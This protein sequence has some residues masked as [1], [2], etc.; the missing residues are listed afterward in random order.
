LEI[1]LRTIQRWQRHQNEPDQRK[2]AAEHRLPENKL[3][4]KERD[5]IIIICNQKQFANMAP[6]QIVPILADQGSYVASES[7]FYRVLRQKDQLAHRGKAKAPKH[8]RPDGIEATICASVNC[9]STRSCL[10]TF[11]QYSPALRIT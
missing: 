11:A 7:S 4:E 1:S 2:S 6:S 8:K 10:M 5:Q 9:K 3:S